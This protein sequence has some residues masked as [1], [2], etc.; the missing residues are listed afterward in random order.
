MDNKIVF[1]NLDI[2][3]KKITV[4]LF[5]LISFYQILIQIKSKIKN[6]YPFK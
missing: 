6:N 5:F 4:C 1:G 3:I 2:F